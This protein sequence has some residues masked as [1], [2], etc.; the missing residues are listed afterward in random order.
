MAISFGVST[1]EEEALVVRVWAGADG[2]I[3]ARL[4]A[5]DL[6]TITIG[7]DKTLAAFAAWLDAATADVP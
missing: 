3:R 7:R 1:D 5:D 6:S 4:T 2:S